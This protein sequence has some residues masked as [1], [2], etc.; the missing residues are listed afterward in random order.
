MATG[1]IRKIVHLSMQS[2]VSAD[3]SP[4]PKGYGYLTSDEGGDDV[5]FDAKAVQLY[6]F[7][8]LQ[9]DQPVEYTADPKLPLA[10]SVTPVEEIESPPPPQITVALGS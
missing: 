7:D 10:K 3:C 9:V 4:A 2:A 5:Y 8:D 6:S 1:T